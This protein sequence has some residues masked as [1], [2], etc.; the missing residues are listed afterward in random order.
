MP[1]DDL[2]D[3]VRVQPPQL[4]VDLQERREQI[5]AGAGIVQLGRVREDFRNDALQ[6]PVVEL[7][8]AAAERLR[9]DV[10]DKRRGRLVARLVAREHRDRRRSNPDRAAAR[11]RPR[12]APDRLPASPAPLAG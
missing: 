9:E 7:D 10:V 4:A 1:D 12:E 6:K 5:A 3:A 2:G 8:A 11:R